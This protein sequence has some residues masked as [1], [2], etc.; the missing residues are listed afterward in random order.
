MFISYLLLRVWG[1]RGLRF[2]SAVSGIWGLGILGFSLQRGQT[3][4]ANCCMSSLC[5]GVD[6]AGDAEEANRHYNGHSR[7]EDAD[8]TCSC[9]VG[10]FRWWRGAL[11]QLLPS[12][13]PAKTKKA[14]MPR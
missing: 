4:E 13:F 8:D 5:D 11:F 14:T 1:L 3:P 9:Y 12:E 10:L 7:A 6:D 2:R